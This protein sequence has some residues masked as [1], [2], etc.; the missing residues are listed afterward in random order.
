ML[1]SLIAT[2]LLV[3][4]PLPFGPAYARTVVSA[5]VQDAAA[6]VA[7]PG[8][9]DTRIQ[10]PT[11]AGSSSQLGPAGAV[12]AGEGPELVGLGTWLANY[13]A[14]TGVRL[15]ADEQVM[16]TIRD[17]RVAVFGAG[18]DPAA[19]EYGITFQNLMRSR[20]FVLTP[21]GG[22]NN[23]EIESVLEP[24]AQG[25]ASLRVDAA[26]RDFM[27]ANPAV[28]M[29]TTVDVVGTDVR[30][31]AVMLRPLLSR[32]HDQLLQV[33]SSGILVTS[34]GDRM[35]QV[36][37]AID[38]A[39]GLGAG[40]SATIT[41]PN[42]RAERASRELA[43]RFFEI[44]SPWPKDVVQTL[45]RLVD[46]RMSAGKLRRTWISPEGHE[47]QWPQVRFYPNADYSRLLVQGAEEDMEMV[48]N[49]LAL[50]L[51][52]FEGQPDGE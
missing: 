50:A 2:T 41:S 23:Y 1:A 3:C 17:A 36:L 21:N 22:A 5:P 34:T 6:L 24:G 43:T 12:R 8:W 7:E 28:L 46:A 14:N 31:L 35:L 38:A 18:F 20:D 37:A 19:P 26:K 45:D 15:T 47:L 30:Q 32:N 44:D 25:W 51:R 29:T 16:A 52:L 48:A 10:E 27:A 11:I 39:S 49:D 13:C 42:A 40:S 4:P 33:G 9:H